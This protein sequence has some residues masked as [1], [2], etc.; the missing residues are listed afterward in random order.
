MFRE[1]WCNLNGATSHL[2][3]GFEWKKSSSVAVATAVP[4]QWWQE[5]E[6]AVSSSAWLLHY[7]SVQEQCQTDFQAQSVLLPVF[8]GGLGRIYSLLILFC[9]LIKYIS[10][11]E[12][13]QTGCHN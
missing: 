4:A 9:L 13:K 7:A 8:C 6:I 1:Q 12:N 5:P 3:T 11:K 2:G 10:N